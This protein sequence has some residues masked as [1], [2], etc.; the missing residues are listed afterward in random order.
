MTRRA[1]ETERAGPTPLD[2]LARA[3]E[4]IARLPPH[5]R[6]SGAAWS[7][8]VAHVLHGCRDGRAW[9]LVSTLAQKL[10]LSASAV[11]RARAALT[12]HG[13]LEAVESRRGG[14]D[15]SATYR[16]VPDARSGAA[17]AWLRAGKVGRAK[18]VDASSTDRTGTVDD[19]ST[20]R[21]RNGA[22]GGAQTVD[23]SARNGGRLV[24]PEAA[25]TRRE[26]PQPPKVAHA[27]HS[28]RPGP[29]YP[30]DGDVELRVHREERLRAVCADR[31]IH[32]H[33]MHGRG[34][35]AELARAGVTATELA[36]WIDAELDST[37][38]SRPEIARAIETGR[39]ARAMRAPVGA[40]DAAADPAPG[41][42]A[43]PRSAPSCSAIA[44]ADPDLPAETATA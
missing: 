16:V 22:Q 36:A 38:S 37:E 43:A 32:L 25:G 4:R 31:E 17:D 1:S 10:G 2:R 18:T 44:G 29:D 15:V 20:D 11:K 12:A 30:G 24:H 14:R 40:A 28:A 23:I 7:V 5:E 3:L 8:L 39:A 26:P 6:F 35:I 13:L 21:P 33:P 9:P 34:G 42:P 19:A 41:D 27:A